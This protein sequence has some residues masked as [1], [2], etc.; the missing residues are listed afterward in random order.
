MESITEK[1]QRL[2]C[3]KLHG[4]VSILVHLF[5]FE[6]IESSELDDLQQCKNIS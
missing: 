5:D 4:L 6:S 2:C 1:P 3:L